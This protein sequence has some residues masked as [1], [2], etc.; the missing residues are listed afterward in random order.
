MRKRLMLLWTPVVL[1]LALLLPTSTMAASGYSY[2]TLYDYC[3]SNYAVHFKVKTI[4]AGWTDANKITTESWAQYKYFGS[5]HT[6]FHWKTSV[7]KFAEDGTQHWLTVW[8]TYSGGD[9]QGRIVFRLNVWH[10]TSLLAQSTVHSV[11]C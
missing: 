9:V 7:Y 6:D 4:A 3:D 5:W 10:N 11:A 1:G 2:K 8:H